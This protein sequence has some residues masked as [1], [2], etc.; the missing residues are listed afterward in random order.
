MNEQMHCTPDTRQLISCLSCFLRDNN[1]K[2]NCYQHPCQTLLAP[3]G[4]SP[5]P[6][7]KHSMLRASGKGGTQELGEQRSQCW[8]LESQKLRLLGIS[9]LEGGL[10]NCL[11]QFLPSSP[12]LQPPKETAQERRPGWKNRELRE[13]KVMEAAGGTPVP[14]FLLLPG[15]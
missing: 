2:R 1:L 4:S 11:G 9:G 10:G 8:I 7:L 13:A 6:Q 15:V 14:I 3:P 5:F 12:D